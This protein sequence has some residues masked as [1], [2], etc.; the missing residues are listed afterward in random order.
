VSGAEQGYPE[1]L[2]WLVCEREDEHPGG[3]AAWRK[4]VQGVTE[5]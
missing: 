4:C 2:G 1:V 5:D 3:L